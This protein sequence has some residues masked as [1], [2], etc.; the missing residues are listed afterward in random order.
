M[1]SVK[2]TLVTEKGYPKATIVEKDRSYS[3]DPFIVKKVTQAK[4]MMSKVK[5]PD[6]LKKQI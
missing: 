4:E 2:H 5:L 3:N 1:S 6:F